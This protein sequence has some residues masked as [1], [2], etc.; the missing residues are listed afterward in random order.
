MVIISNVQQDGSEDTNGL[1]KGNRN[2]NPFILYVP[3][4]CDMIGELSRVS[5]KPQLFILCSN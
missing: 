3:A 1:V 5:L 4:I 2:F